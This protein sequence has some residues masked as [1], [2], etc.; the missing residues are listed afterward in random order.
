MNLARKYV[1][2]DDEMQ[3][4]SKASKLFTE[5]DK[6]CYNAEKIMLEFDPE[7]REA[8]RRLL[9]E[10]T[11]LQLHADEFADSESDS[12]SDGGQQASG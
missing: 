1:I 9:F 12:S 2:T 6:F 7:Q 5:G 4:E 8:D 11:G 10:I 3:A